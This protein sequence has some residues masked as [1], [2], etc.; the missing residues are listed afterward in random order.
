MQKCDVSDS[1]W[2]LQLYA[3]VYWHKS[4]HKEMVRGSLESSAV[5]IWPAKKQT[6]KQVILM[7]VYI[8]LLYHIWLKR[9]NEWKIPYLMVRN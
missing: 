7:Q 8:H 1:V 6:M 4:E 5:L 2:S 9:W 3:C